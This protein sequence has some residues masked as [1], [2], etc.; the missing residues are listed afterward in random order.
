MSSLLVGQL[1][2]LPSGYI[3]EERR[4]LYPYGPEMGVWCLFTKGEEN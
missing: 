1:K 2:E 4:N 3:Q